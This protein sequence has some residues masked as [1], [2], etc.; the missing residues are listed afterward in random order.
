MKE[1]NVPVEDAIKRGPANIVRVRMALCVHEAG[2]RGALQ[3]ILR[4][5]GI[6]LPHDE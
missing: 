5:E 6:N 2:H 3:T 1:N 4:L